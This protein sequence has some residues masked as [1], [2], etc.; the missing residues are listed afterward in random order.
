MAETVRSDDP[1]EQAADQPAE[2][3]TEDWSLLVLHHLDLA[4][5]LAR[6]YT[7]RGEPLDELIQVA[8]LGLVKAARRYDPGRGSFSSFA[9]PTILGELRRH[10]RD[11]CWAVN[12]PR[13]LRDL[14]VAIQQT[15]EAL[16]TNLGR[17]PTV[18]EI[19]DELGVSQEQIV[20][21]QESGAAY[22]PW[23]LQQPAT[24]LADDTA[25]SMGDTIRSEDEGFALVENREALR[26]LLPQVPE[27][28]RRILYLRFYRDR[29]QA[30]IGR[31]LGLSQMHVS[32]LIE[33]TVSK[34]R[35]AVL[36]DQN[37]LE[38][39]VARPRSSSRE[40]SARQLEKAS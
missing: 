35:D 38:W 37:V 20:E 1:V 19:A 6:R 3:G 4:R 29:T 30:Q 17:A 15:S 23:S 22:R 25:P 8:R 14:Y 36:N 21:A 2:D 34:L 12:V 16:G 18:S 40:R 39:P 7:G 26:H 10:F 11:R 5:R 27:R 28:E 13:R 32:R 33:Q 9:I 24:R 31:E